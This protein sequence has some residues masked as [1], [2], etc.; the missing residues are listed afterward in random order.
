MQSNQS[1]DLL[2]IM[3]TRGFRSSDVLS[4]NKL[5][6]CKRVQDIQCQIFSIYDECHNS[7]FSS[8]CNFSTSCFYSYTSHNITDLLKSQKHLR[9]VKKLL[10]SK[11]KV[12]Y[13]YTFYQELLNLQEQRYLTSIQNRQQTPYRCN[14]ESFLTAFM[15]ENAY[16]TT[17]KSILPASVVCHQFRKLLCKRDADNDMTKSSHPCHPCPMTSESKCQKPEGLKAPISF[18]EIF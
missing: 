9:K 5:I 4:S 7:D 3:K 8:L 16:D 14:Q 13:L 12:L 1:D 18:L 15:E 11:A 6:F 17:F 2:L 10:T